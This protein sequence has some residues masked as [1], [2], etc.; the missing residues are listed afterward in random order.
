MKTLSASSTEIGKVVD[1]ITGIA[2]QTNLLALNATIEAARAGESGK[3]FAVVAH[4][5]KELAQQTAQATS[6]IQTRIESLRRD[7]ASA[8]AAITGIA[9]VIDR[10]VELQAT[11]GGSIGEQV[12]T[13][14]EIG[15]EVTLAAEGA[16]GIDR[17]IADVALSAQSASAGAQ[18]VRSASDQLANLSRELESFVGAFRYD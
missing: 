18:E 1:L 15:R 8:M 7:A 13:S 9:R 3:G 5:V 11:V 6:D 4:E 2:A 10:I 16:S 14:V 17:G 12:R